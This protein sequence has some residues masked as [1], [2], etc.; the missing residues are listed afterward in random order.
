MRSLIADDGAADLIDQVQIDVVPHGP[1]LQQ[2]RITLT[3]MRLTQEHRSLDLSGIDLTTVPRVGP[4]QPVTVHQVQVR[5]ERIDVE[6]VAVRA[7]VQAQA[8]PV[9][10]AH[11]GQEN[12]WALMDLDQAASEAH[13][14]G[15]VSVPREEAV[16]RV[17]ALVAGELANAGVT[18]TDLDVKVRTPSGREIVLVARARVR[19]GLL[20]A[21]AQF[22][23]TAGVDEQMRLHVGQVQA[24]SGNPV[25][26]LVLAA[27]RSRL[28]RYAGTTIDL[29][30]HLPAG[31]RL[32]DLQVGA[33]QFLQAQARFA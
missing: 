18:L 4:A 16:Q 3:G 9:F 29:H 17:R 10:L 12:L 14:D 19:K 5:A 15:T 27:V 30:D 11:D 7:H 20:A 13:G 26:A 21:S 28:D 32:V 6:G 23:V 31:L 33:G 8:L 24:H 2:V 25:V 1:D 22:Q